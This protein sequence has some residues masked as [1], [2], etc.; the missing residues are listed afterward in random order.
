MD[1][2]LYLTGAAIWIVV[3]VFG[4]CLACEILLGLIA[5][6]SWFR[7]QYEIKRRHAPSWW[8]WRRVPGVV[9]KMWWTLTGYRPDSVTIRSKF[10]E[11][12]GVGNWTVWES[13]Q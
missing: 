11:W 8:K 10:G 6:C 7:W 2:T 4:I 13:E 5:A 1:L 9:L 3:G 12:R